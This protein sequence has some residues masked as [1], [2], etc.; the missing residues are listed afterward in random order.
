M[1]VPDAGFPVEVIRG[2]PVVTAPE[3]ID[4]INAAGLRRALLQAVALG[5]GTFVVDMSHTRFCDTA[6]IHALVGAHKRARAEGGQ[7]LLVI[8]AAAVH[9]ILSITGL[10][11][12][13]LISRTWNRLWRKHPP[14]TRTGR[15]QEPNRRVRQV[16]SPCRLERLIRG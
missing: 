13:S 10:D 3:D 15:S 12:G 6:G 14:R 9:R 7:M 4:I 8:G 2:V 5:H 16:L 1:Q 11:R